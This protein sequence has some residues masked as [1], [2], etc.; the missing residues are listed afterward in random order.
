VIFAQLST[1]SRSCSD[2]SQFG[3][4]TH[5]SWLTQ[6]YAYAVFTVQ[7]GVIWRCRNRYAVTEC[8]T[9]NGTY[10]AITGLTASGATGEATSADY[11]CG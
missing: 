7:F 8:A 1:T 4:R 11:R 3:L 10:T 6:G 5:L 2:Q 9:T